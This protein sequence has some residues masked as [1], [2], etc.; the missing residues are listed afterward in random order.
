MATSDGIVFSQGTGYGYVLGIGFFFAFVMMGI[1]ALQ[2]RYTTYKTSNAEEYNTASRSV[3]PG[4]IASGIVSAWTWAATLLQSCTITYEYGICGGYY[5]AAGATL[6]V[7]LM[8][9]LAV[10]VKMIAPYCHT[11]LE[12]I[13]ARYGSTAH[14]VFATFATVQILIASSMLLLGG[15]AVVN[16]LTGMNIYAANF[17]IPV[18]VMIYVILGGLRATFLCDYTHT[19]I[20]MIVLLYFFFYTYTRSDLIGG[21]DGMYRLLQKAGEE[22]PAAGNE[23]GSYLTMK[24]NYGLCFMIIQ[25]SGAFGVVTLDQGYWQRAIASQAKTTVYAYL[26]G[27]I[28]WFAVPLTMSMVMGLTA[29]AL[30]DSPYFPYLG[31]LTATEVGDGLA[32]PAAVIAVLGRSGAAALLLILFMAVTSA[33]SS[34]MIGM[35]SIL[36][37]DIYQIH[38]NPHASPARLIR[39]SHFMVGAWAI[40]MSCI[41]SLWIGI[42]VSLN[43]LYLFAGIL[44]TPAAGPII[45]TMLWRKHTGAAAVGGALGGLCMGIMTW[46]LVARFH[47]GELTITSTGNTYSTMAGNLASLCCGAIFSALITLVKPDNEFDW[48]QTKNINPHGRAL[49]RE[50]AR[51]TEEFAEKAQESP[52]E[53]TAS[54]ESDEQPEYYE[55]LGKSLTSAAWVS[56]I[57]SFIIVFLIPIPLFLSHYIFS[58]RF[59]KAWIIISIIW[60]I[61]AAVITIIL[62]VWESR[63]AMLDI[64]RGLCRDLFRNRR[65]AGSRTQA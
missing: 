36:T 14:F 9:I 26:M 50:R 59:F 38:I 45:M 35:S 15:S 21:L 11:Y 24:S 56:V 3:K 61:V 4:L 65:R 46:L 8:S 48:S 13:H 16:A 64:G 19:S 18:G 63:E 54:A 34:E 58:L 55:T 49:D 7:F 53:K 5:Y 31:G 12:V 39:V 10:R 1:S 47:Y 57:L 33:A 30:A 52:L 43:W 40:L 41:S 42:G 29:V 17:L 51:M 25:L 44:Y 20:L 6:E 27:G 37:Y 62:P 60:L 23:G 2:N 28:S 32:A 22:R